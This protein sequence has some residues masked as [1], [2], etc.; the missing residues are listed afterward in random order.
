MLTSSQ[1][2]EADERRH[3]HNSQGSHTAPASH[4]DQLSHTAA[5]SHIAC[6]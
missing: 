2:N 6:S 1:A 5:P 4:S 3:G